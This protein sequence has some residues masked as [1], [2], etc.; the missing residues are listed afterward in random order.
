M[1]IVK[2]YSAKIE[3]RIVRLTYDTNTNIV[4]AVCKTPES[5]S[6]YL[7]QMVIEGNIGTIDAIIYS[8]SLRNKVIYMIKGDS[9][10]NFLRDTSTETKPKG[11]KFTDF[12]SENK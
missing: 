6:K 5:A 8:K 12:L 3:N 4:R 11:K 2:K 10:A 9:I 1:G 7:A